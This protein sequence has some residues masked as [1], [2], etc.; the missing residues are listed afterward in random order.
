[1]F[2]LF[3]S[4]SSDAVRLRRSAAATSEARRTSYQD[5]T[6]RTSQKKALIIGLNYF[7]TDN[8]CL[9]CIENSNTF[10]ACLKRKLHVTDSTI[11]HDFDQKITKTTI[12]NAIDEISVGCDRGDIIF[13]Y[14]AGQSLNDALIISETESITLEEIQEAILE[15]LPRG[16]TVVFVLDCGIEKLGL[17]HCY[18]D[19][20]KHNSRESLI[21]H[22]ENM[23]IPETHSSI[24]AISHGDKS[25]R[26]VL[27]TSFIKCIEQE[28]THTLKMS[29]FLEMM[30]NDFVTKFVH[31]SPKFE[32]GQL[33]DIAVPFGRIVAAPI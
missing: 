31:V 4:P 20:R 28:Y 26:G 22:D 5:T 14:F 9:G 3:S 33:I 32:F 17:R 13:V 19:K 10:S 27:T 15:P 7:G 12:F 30:M 18:S 6:R 29:R 2:S 25:S 24:I 21:T 23:T 8:Q 1:M 11:L 16:V